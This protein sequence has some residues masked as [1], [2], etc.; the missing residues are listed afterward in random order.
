MERDVR[1]STRQ[2]LASPQ[3]RR[4][5]FMRNKTALII[6]PFSTATIANR[7]KI[8]APMRA[9][10]KARIAIDLVQQVFKSFLDISVLSHPRIPYKH[11]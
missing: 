6:G 11:L 1:E 8:A 4:T 10:V 3:D 5:I 7:P 9:F 2:K